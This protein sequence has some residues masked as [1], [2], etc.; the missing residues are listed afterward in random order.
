MAGMLLLA[1]MG[2]GSMLLARRGLTIPEREFR[3]TGGVVLFLL[4]DHARWSATDPLPRL[5]FRSWRPQP[6]PCPVQLP[7]SIMA[8]D[9]A[10]R[11]GLSG[12]HEAGC[13]AAYRSN[14]VLPAWHGYV[15]G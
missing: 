12:G 13:L 11:R 5:A 9:K 15:G 3:S 6:N 4:V 7:A 14:F 2:M 1:D 10:V 8:L